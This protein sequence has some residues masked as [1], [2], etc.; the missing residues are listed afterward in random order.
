MPAFLTEDAM[1]AWL[2]PVKLDRGDRGGM[3]SLLDAAS[4]D[5]ASTI[6]QY[7]VDRKMN[8][9]RGV[10]TTDPSVIAPAA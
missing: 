2:G 9:S 8:N 5:V 4:A 3:L 1:V 6:R 10:D 7:V